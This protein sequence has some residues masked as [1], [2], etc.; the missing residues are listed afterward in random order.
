MI[1]SNSGA[2]KTLAC[3]LSI[4]LVNLSFP[5]GVFVPERK[6]GAPA[7]EEPKA[8][9]SRVL[10]AKEMRTLKGK[11]SKNP[12]FAGSGKW[13]VNFRG[14]DALTGTFST[15][16]TDLSFEGGYG[17][18]VNVTRSYSSNNADEGPL[19]EGWTLS[20]DIRTT[21]GGLLKGPGSGVR[22]VPTM[23]KERAIGQTDPRDANTPVDAVVATDA[24]GYEE[25]IQKDVDGVLT[26][27]PWDKNVHEPKY[28]VVTNTN[29]TFWV[30][31]ENTTRTAEGTVY[32]YQKKGH[33]GTAGMLPYGASSGDAKPSNVLKIVSVTDRHGNATTYTY[34]TTDVTFDRT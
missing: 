31:T 13:G 27:P 3:V 25:V 28:E 19:G 29:G 34:D 18:P 2:G 15:S 11:T 26:T 16:A 9:C 12:Y 1:R 8:P 20:V 24:S 30:L 6:P 4:A 14:I 21:A 32:V 5:F 17:I 7:P 10:S 23:F 22:S 33:F